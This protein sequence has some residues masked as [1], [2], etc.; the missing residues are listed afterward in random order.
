MGTRAMPVPNT[1]K[2]I[3]VNRDVRSGLDL[4][5]EDI[6]EPG[7]GEDEIGRFITTRHGQQRWSDHA[8][9]SVIM[10]LPR[11]VVIYYF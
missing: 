11:L 5:V 2:A 7:V 1:R 3:G 10:P 9:S 4:T 6:H 8:I